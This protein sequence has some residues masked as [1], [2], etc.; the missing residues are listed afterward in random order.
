MKL[1]F[2]VFLIAHALIHVSYLTPPPPR[3]AGGPEWPFELTRSWLV[4]GFA[5]DP[6]VARSA[7][8][9]LVIVTAILLVAAG[10]STLGIGIPV[11]WWPNLVVAGAV[12]S[13]LTLALYFHPW[14]AL[15]LVIDAALLYA[16]LVA[17]WTPVAVV[18]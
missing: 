10:L 13:A 11:S 4:T 12:A 5:V 9:M 6:G 16:V 1:L 3:T 8:A 7:G 2:G 17:Q 14:L 18:R 15:G